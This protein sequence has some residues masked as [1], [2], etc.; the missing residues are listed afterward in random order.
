M[1]CMLYIS[2]QDLSGFK[3]SLILILT[4]TCDFQ[5]CGILTC[6]D[7]DESVQSPFKFRNSKWCSASSLTVIE[8]SSN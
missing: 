3:Q 6:V 7:S 5:Q 1:L 2:K 8:Y 4:G